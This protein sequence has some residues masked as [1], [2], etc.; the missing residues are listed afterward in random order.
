MSTELLASFDDALN[1]YKTDLSNHDWYYSY[2]DD[3]RVYF[4]GQKNGEHLYKL[5]EESGIAFKI[6]YNE[7][8]AKHFLKL[9]SVSFFDFD[10][11]FEV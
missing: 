7:E 1:Q 5:A 4:A 8:W 2:S 9:N 11:P 3:N 6:A 10:L